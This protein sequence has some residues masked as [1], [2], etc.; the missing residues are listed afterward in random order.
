MMVDKFVLFAYQNLHNYCCPFYWM[1]IRNYAK[2][3][4]MKKPQNILKFKLLVSKFF[5]ITPNNVVWFGSNLILHSRDPWDKPIDL[6]TVAHYR[7][8]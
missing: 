3:D 8:K 7:F 2:N 5:F 4:A 1:G 6:K